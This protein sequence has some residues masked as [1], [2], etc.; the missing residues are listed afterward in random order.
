MIISPIF[1]T[2]SLMAVIAVIS[3]SVLF[4]SYQLEFRK[5]APRTLRFFQLYFY[6]G[7]IGWVCLCL[8]ELLSIQMP[9]YALITPYFLASYLLLYMLVAQVPFRK[10]G[11]LWL[12]SHLLFV[13]M[14]LQSDSTGA[15]LGY[16]STY[17]I[18]HMPVLLWVSLKFR[19][20]VGDSIFTLAILIPLLLNLPQAYFLTKG[21]HQIV[22]GIALIG[23]ATSFSLVALGFMT[24]TL[25]SHRDS[26]QSLADRDP[27]T[28]LYNRR[29]LE[30]RLD[31]LGELNDQDITPVSAV[32][33]DIDHFKR[34]NDR[35][36]HDIGDI[37]IKNYSA[38]LLELSRSSDIVARLGGEEFIL[39]LPQTDKKDALKLA[40]RLR[41]SVENMETEVGA[42]SF[43]FTSSFGVSS[44]DPLVN[45]DELMKE[46]DKSLYLAK[47]EGRNTVV[48]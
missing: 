45:T 26:L 9:L 2:M 48:G 36:G 1:F 34:I 35:Y 25:V 6:G 7:G 4:A 23:S 20:N 33:C 15:T 29:G 38:K 37:V 31:R 14:I 22:M 42:N 12:G 19:T 32:A 21:D 43:K 30:V 13:F 28:G 5:R 24:M 27:L 46:A 17:I 11:A 18:L 47:Q 44:Q 16:F 41:E 3:A 39:I 8:V 10:Y 40:E